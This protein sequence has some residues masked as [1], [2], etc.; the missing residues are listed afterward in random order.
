VVVAV[1]IVPFVLAVAWALVTLVRP[2]GEQEHAFALLLVPLGA[3]LTFE[4]AS[5][6]LRFTPGAFVQDR[7]LVYLVPLLAVAGATAA[8]QQRCR[9]IL[10]ALTVAASLGVVWLAG[11]VSFAGDAIF[12]AAPAAAFHPALES[13][14]DAAGAAPGS[15]VRAAAL[16][17]GLA[18]AAA[19][20]RAPAAPTVLAIGI[21]VAAFGAL[22]TVYV[23]EQA[24]VPATKR[25]STIVIPQ[26]DWIDAAVA[27]E[28]SVALVP[29]P[30]LGPGVWW[31]VEFWN[32]TV[33]RVFRIDGAPTFTPFPADDL[34]FEFATGTL[35]GGEKTDLLVVAINETRFHFAEAAP[36]ARVPP[37]RLVRVERPL[38]A[39]WA[40]RGADVDGWT[41]PGTPVTV[42]LYPQAAPEQREVTVTVSAAREAR[43]PVEYSLEADGSAAQGTTAPGTFSRVQ[44]SVCVPADAPTDLTLVTRGATRLPEG[45]IVA[46]HVD[47]VEAA[48][49]G[50][51]R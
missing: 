28:A 26:R 20:W 33:D 17:L 30:Y 5:F 32:K 14:A 8:I 15:V 12:W 18:A 39:D 46:A 51:C 16:A 47:S 6:D 10:A 44:V 27:D 49:A 45:R 38:R 35:R 37:L 48:G 25:P 22:Q 23:F 36:L 2:V 1:G 19:V 29:N 42:R 41:R 50:P 34:S 43:A 24:A 13:V 7:Y 40:T 31:D 3:L 21:A 9:G 4:A 11:F